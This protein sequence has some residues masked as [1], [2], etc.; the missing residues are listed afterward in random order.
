VI[1]VTSIHDLELRE[2]RRNQDR[3]K[4]R[5]THQKCLAWHRW[6]DDATYETDMKNQKYILKISPPTE[7][8]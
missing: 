2:T 5:R 3:E 7:C 1:N 6:L 8:A 4:N